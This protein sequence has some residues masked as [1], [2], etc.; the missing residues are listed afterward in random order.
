MKCK[1]GK[2]F[3][4][5]LT[6][7]NICVKGKLVNANDCY[8]ILSNKRLEILN[9]LSELHKDA[10]TVRNQ[11]KLN[12]C[13]TQTEQN[14]ILMLNNSVSCIFDIMKWYMKEIIC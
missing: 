14:E 13:A 3:K 10:E 6:F 7:N 8:N 4:L 1:I 2:T 11:I 9:N 5:A 12:E